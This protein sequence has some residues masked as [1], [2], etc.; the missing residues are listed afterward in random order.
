MLFLSP[1][2]GIPSI[3]ALTNMFYFFKFQ[4]HVQLL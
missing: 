1:A 3:R 4:I 2:D